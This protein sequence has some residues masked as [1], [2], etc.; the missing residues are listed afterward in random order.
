MHMCPG[1]DAD[2]H[3][4]GVCDEEDFSNQQAKWIIR[5]MLLSKQ[6]S[7]LV[8]YTGVS[9]PHPFSWI[10]SMCKQDHHAK[11]ETIKLPEEIMRELVCNF[12]VRKFINTTEKLEA[13]I[14][15]NGKF[16]HLIIKI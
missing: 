9:T 8:E 1:I 5:M 3:R 13:P 2:I 14:E 16:D 10:N 11:N 7:R 12:G 4:H 6:G 15:N